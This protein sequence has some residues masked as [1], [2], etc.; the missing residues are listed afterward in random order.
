LF[1]CLPGFAGDGPARIR[2]RRACPDSQETGLP[3]FAGDGFYCSIVIDILL[4]YRSSPQARGSARSCKRVHIM[5][6]K[7]FNPGIL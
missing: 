4:K 3:G 1:D 5:A 2:R 6:A 7:V